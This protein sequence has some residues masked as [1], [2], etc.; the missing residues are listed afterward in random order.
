MEMAGRSSTRSLCILVLFGVTVLSAF[1]LCDGTP[2]RRASALIGKWLSLS[3]CDCDDHG[4]SQ[5]KRP[6]GQQLH[7]PVA[8]LRSVVALAAEYQEDP[9][10]IP[11]S[12][13]TFAATFVIPASL[14]GKKYGPLIQRDLDAAIAAYAARQLPLFQDGAAQPKRSSIREFLTD[15]IPSTQGKA[16]FSSQGSES[17]SVAAQKPPVHGS[18]RRALTDIDSGDKT[19]SITNFLLDGSS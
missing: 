5:Q 18:S 11:P 13:T 9:A 4:N 16:A 8:G 15:A 7:S 19:I 17:L 3:S 2:E 1:K 10:T 12:D 14:V 6:A